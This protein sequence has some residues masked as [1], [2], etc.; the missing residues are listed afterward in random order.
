MGL[1]ANRYSVSFGVDESVPKL[2]VLNRVM[3]S[4]HSECTETIE[5]CPLDGELRMWW[6]EK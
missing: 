5:S 6:P 1:T 3:V 2:S 4:H